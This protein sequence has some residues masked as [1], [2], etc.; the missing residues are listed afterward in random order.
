MELWWKFTR[1][2]IS[3][4]ESIFIDVIFFFSLSV[5]SFDFLPFVQENESDWKLVESKEV[6]EHHIDFELFS[7]IHWLFW[8]E[9]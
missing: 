1:K 6:L 7:F 8:I 2:K 3:E 4:A 9:W 5:F